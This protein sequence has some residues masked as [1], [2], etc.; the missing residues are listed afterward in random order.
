MA[1]PIPMNDLARIHAPLEDALIASATAVIRSGRYIQGP[2]VDAFEREAAAY[3]G[4]AHAV[5]TSSGTDALLVA[6]MAL[7]IEPGDEVVTTPYTFFATAGTI[8]RLGGIPVFADIEEESFNLD[9]AEAARRVTPRTR[10]LLPV[11]L[12]GRCADMAA[13]QTV[14]TAHGLPIVEDAAQS[15][16]A[17][18]A[19]GRRA[20]SMGAVGCFS[21]FPAKNL[22]ALG[23][24]GFVTTNDEALA[25]TI[26]VLRVHGGSPKYHHAVIGG[27]FRLDALQAA[28]L[29]VKL[30][31]LDAWT[32]ARAECAARYRILLA[33][34]GVDELVRLPPAGDGR[35]AW[36]QLCARATERDA[37]RQHLAEAA[38]TTEIYYPVPLHLQPC[39]RYLG[40]GPG[41]FPVAE[42]A[43]RSALALPVFPGLRADEQ[44]RVADS[45][46][47]FYAGRGLV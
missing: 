28:L 16:G 33:D 20:G 41:D 2:E 19:D 30:P 36:N 23:D 45:I 34:R 7:G 3:C 44:E 17:E 15:I 31:H 5:G 42:Q 9:P 18:A 4:A 1:T 22:G 47:D 26:R 14:A 38:I 46:H 32:A 13:L 10:A 24:A 37:L 35:H 8:H 12:F 11:H 29:R 40:H 6:L 27:N 25:R 43:A 21:A 39:F